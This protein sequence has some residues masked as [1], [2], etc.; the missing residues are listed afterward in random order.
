MWDAEV[1]GGKGEVYMLQLDL[2]PKWKQGALCC[3]TLG[4]GRF[5]LSSAA[6]GVRIRR[7]P[8]HS[9]QFPARIPIPI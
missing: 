1:V 5:I 3:A 4:L 6:R 8:K 9:G 2:V 7:M